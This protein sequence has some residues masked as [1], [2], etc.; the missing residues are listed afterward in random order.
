MAVVIKFIITLAV[1]TGYNGDSFTV[2]L[3]S[4][5]ATE[6][7]HNSIR[8]LYV[9]RPLTY[10]K[11]LADNAKNCVSMMAQN[12]LGIFDHPCQESGE[13]IYLTRQ[14]M[15]TGSSSPDQLMS[16]AVQAWHDEVR[17]TKQ[18]RLR[19]FD[20]NWLK[21][22]SKEDVINTGHLM[23]MLWANTQYVG[24]ASDFYIENGDRVYYLLCRYDSP[25]NIWNLIERLNNLP[26]YKPGNDCFDDAGCEKVATQVACAKYEKTRTRCKLSCDAYLSVKQC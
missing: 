14:S 17:F 23:Q 5:A 7:T 19:K 12:R 13:S 6:N 3:V 10:S 16:L 25:A 26:V 4:P 9:D 18:P 15:Q 1:I 21:Y 20:E 24:C 11:A 8:N 2:Q 22:P